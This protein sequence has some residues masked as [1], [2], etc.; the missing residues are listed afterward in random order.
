VADAAALLTVMA[1]SDPADAATRE[2]DARKQ[3]YSAALNPQAL[4][5]KR[6]GVARFLAGY[7]SGTDVA[8]ERALATFKA[9]GALLI[10]LKEGPDRRA[11]GA[12]EFAVLLSEFKAGLNTYLASTDPAK[13]PVRDLAGVIAA[14]SQHPSALNLFGQDLLVQ[15]QATKGLEDP[16]YQKALAT[17][18]RLAGPEGIDALVRTHQLDAI[19]APTGAPAWLTD[20]VLGDHFKGGS[21][22]MAAVAGYPNITVPMGQV[23]SLPVGLS[24][25]GPAWS[26]ATL[27]SIAYGFEQAHQ[28]RVPPPSR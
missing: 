15:A 18:R 9:Q 1:G 20:A 17:A 8:F 28:G 3:D 23:R 26:E 6:I 5:G 24:I 2:A 14:N 13:V 16:D 21:S 27:I 10:D 25:F 11:L 7:H 4:A 19:I 22:S 12:A